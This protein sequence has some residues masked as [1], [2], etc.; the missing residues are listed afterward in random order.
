[1]FNILGS[2]IIPQM[3]KKEVSSTLNT[4]ESFVVILILIFH[5][6][7]SSIGRLFISWCMSVLLPNNLFIVHV[8]KP[9]WWLHTSLIHISSLGSYILLVAP[10]E[11]LLN[12]EITHYFCNLQMGPGFPITIQSL[13]KVADQYNRKYLSG[14][15]RWNLKL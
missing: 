13:S 15:V 5:Y 10:T 3:I 2:S 14:V 12:G 8:H 1:M 4:W 7:W 9:K 11:C 6:V